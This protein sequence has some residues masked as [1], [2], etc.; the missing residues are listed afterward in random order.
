M[1]ESIIAP[2]Q[3]LYSTVPKRDIE[4]DSKSLNINE[5]G[6]AYDSS[7]EQTLDNSYQANSRSI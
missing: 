6:P 4:K 7:M 5:S 3:T 2:L 1:G